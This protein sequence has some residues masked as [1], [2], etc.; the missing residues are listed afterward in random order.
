M[1]FNN[2]SLF[3]QRELSEKEDFNTF[4]CKYS[5]CVGHLSAH[6]VR[7]AT[8][9]QLSPIHTAGL[10]ENLYTGCPS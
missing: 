6:P 7:V 1:L 5:A 9:N 8:A 3:F 4:G 10:A 2:S